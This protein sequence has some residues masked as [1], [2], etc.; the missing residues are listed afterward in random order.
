MRIWLSV[1]YPH[2]TLSDTTRYPP[3]RAGI[4][5]LR[6]KVRHNFFCQSGCPTPIVYPKLKSLLGVNVV[7]T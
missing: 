5:W 7:R 6:H 4:E 3:R 1:R 2:L